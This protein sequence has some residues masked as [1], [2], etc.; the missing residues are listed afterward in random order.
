MWTMKRFRS[1]F[2]T[3]AF[4]VALCKIEQLSSTVH[5]F[6]FHR[7]AVRIGRSDVGV[8]VGGSTNKTV[9]KSDLPA[10]LCVVYV[11]PFM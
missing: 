3:S 11:R 6:L 7:T 10:K 1:I 2:A 9:P 4:D 8:G 5:G